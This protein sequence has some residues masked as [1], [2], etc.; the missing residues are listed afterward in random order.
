M[1]IRGYTLGAHRLISGVFGP[2][3]PKSGEFHLKSRKIPLKSGNRPRH[4]LADDREIIENLPR[5]GLFG[6]RFGLRRPVFGE[7]SSA[8]SGFAF[9]WPEKWVNLVMPALRLA[10]FWHH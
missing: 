9:I 7:N 2:F 8:A 1:K 10:P 3:C 6:P 4:T 5:F